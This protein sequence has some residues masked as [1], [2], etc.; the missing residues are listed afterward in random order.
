MDTLRHNLTEYYTSTYN[1]SAD[2][3]TPDD[4]TITTGGSSHSL[5]LSF[6]LLMRGSQG[7]GQLIILAPF[8][9]PYVGMV[10]LANGNEV[11]VDTDKDFLPDLAAIEAAITK[12]TKAI[13]INSPNNPTG[14]VYS[15]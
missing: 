13:L 11:L 15:K 2:A 7:Q 8:F 9:G 12:D 5:S 6:E 4:F 1:L 3:I 10:K 14:K